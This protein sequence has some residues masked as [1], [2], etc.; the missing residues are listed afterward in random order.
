MAA[1]KYS[2]VDQLVSKYDNEKN[3]FKATVKTY[4]AKYNFYFGDKIMMF[5]NEA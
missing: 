5:K 4:L 1:Q 3:H 2:T